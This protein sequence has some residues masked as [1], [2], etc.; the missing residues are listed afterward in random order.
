VCVCVYTTHTDTH[1]YVSTHDKSFQFKKLKR[2]LGF[3]SVVE[4][5]SSKCE[6][7]GSVLGTEK[8]RRKLVFNN[9]IV[10]VRINS[11]VCI[12]CMW[13]VWNKFYIIYFCNVFLSFFWW[14]Y[15]VWTQ[16]MALPLE[17]HPPHVFIFIMR[18]THYFYN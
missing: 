16:G 18:I 11:L 2:D 15:G 5:W 10:L 4:C 8:N 1:T 13:C 9:S 6:A 7:L 3:S 17:P 12:L 14:W